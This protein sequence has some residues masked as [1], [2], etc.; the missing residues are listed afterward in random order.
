MEEIISFSLLLLVLL[1]LF[2]A[3]TFLRKKKA[4]DEKDF[5]LVAKGLVHEIKNPLNSLYINTQLIK[6]DLLTKDPKDMDLSEMSEIVESNLM[7]LKRLNGIITDF[8]RFARPS[9]KKIEKLDICKVLSEVLKFFFVEFRKK[10][11]EVEKF[12]DGKEVLVKG[13]KD[14]IKQVF[15]NIILNSIQAMEEGGKIK[16]W[17]KDEKKNVFVIFEDTGSGIDEDKIKK[18]F[19]PFYST[20]HDG[21]GLGLCMVKKIMEEH[22]GKVYIESKKGEGTRVTL[23]FPKK[24]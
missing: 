24:R 17:I 8:L 18:V 15:F 5:S 9:V 3:L 16:I 7:E 21:T 4:S 19:E 20:K 11:I 14:A 12:Y 1:D 13:D 22:G 10:R 2:L 23:L 6:E